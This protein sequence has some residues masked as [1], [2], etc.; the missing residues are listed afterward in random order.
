MVAGL[1]KT[2]YDEALPA[3]YGTT[4]PKEAMEAFASSKFEWGKIP[5]W[6]PPLE[7]R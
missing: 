5:E 4:L 3:D 6:I 7:V 1:L 2:V